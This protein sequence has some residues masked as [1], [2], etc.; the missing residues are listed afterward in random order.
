MIKGSVAQRSDNAWF[1]FW[2]LNCLES[3]RQKWV[4]TSWHKRDTYFTLS[5]C[6]PFQFQL[7][8]WTASDTNCHLPNFVIRLWH[9]CS[10]TRLLFELFRGWRESYG[11]KQH[12]WQSRLV[13]VFHSAGCDLRSLITFIRVLSYLFTQ[14]RTPFWYLDVYIDINCIFGHFR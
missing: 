12:F 9:S 2:K 6:N 4:Y 10:V 13:F 5:P 8:F 1:G 11:C 7:D 3:R 14:W